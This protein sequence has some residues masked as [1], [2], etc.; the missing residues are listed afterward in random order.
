M[1]AARKILIGLWV[2]AACGV[3]SATS[4]HQD[5]QM[6][7]IRD[8]AGKATGAKILAVLSSDGHKFARLG[9][10]PSRAD[11]PAGRMSDQ[12]IGLKKAIMDR[13][14]KKWLARTPNIDL[15]KGA[16]EVTLLVDYKKTGLKPGAKVQL[17]SAWD[18]GPGQSEHLWGVEWTQNQGDP[19]I[20]LP[21]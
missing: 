12:R 20:T 13:A 9:I 2:V 15:S 6:E 11:M 7:A 4:H 5:V 16:A 8:K 19:E 18:D 10:L 14:S 3:A 17:G 1:T 21:K